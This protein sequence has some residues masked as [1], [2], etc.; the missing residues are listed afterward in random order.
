MLRSGSVI[1]TYH[2]EDLLDEV[3]KLFPG[4]SVI[5]VLVD[6][7]E[8]FVDFFAS[9]VVYSDF[10]GDLVEHLLELSPF[11]EAR[12]IDINFPEGVLHEFLHFL[13]VLHH[14]FELL[15]LRHSI[16]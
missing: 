9:G 6:L 11:E 16:Q 12:T 7:V 14:G 4:D 2:L 15:L 1:E 10:L 13:G 8:D 5:A 3:R